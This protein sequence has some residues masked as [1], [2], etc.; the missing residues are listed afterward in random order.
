MGICISLN[1]PSP[2]VPDSPKPNTM[3]WLI[4]NEKFRNIALLDYP[5]FYVNMEE[6]R[7]RELNRL[8]NL[9]YPDGKRVME[10]FHY[11]ARTIIRR[12]FYE[13]ARKGNI[14]VLRFMW[15]NL[16]DSKGERLF[17]SRETYEKAFD[18]ATMTGHLNVI[19]FLNEIGKL[20]D[21]NYLSYPGILFATEFGQTDILRYIFNKLRTG[22][23]GLKNLEKI[24]DDIKKSYE[25]ANSYAKE[26][27]YEFYKQLG[28]LSLI[29]Q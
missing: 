29:G 9:R 23:D 1:I 17:E 7:I 14:G 19:E 13:V 28:L 22:P 8:W 27:S 24:R 6:D 16:I 11:N 21:T 18:Y 3:D 5:M 15:T 10:E 26:R 12:C 20:P 2:P 4:I 25:K